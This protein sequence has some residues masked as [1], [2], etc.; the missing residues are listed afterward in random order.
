MHCTSTLHALQPLCL[1]LERQPST[2]PLALFLSAP[3][4]AIP[5]MLGYAKSIDIPARVARAMCP[6]FYPHFA[7]SM[8]ASAACVLETPYAAN[9]TVRFSHTIA[10]D[11]PGRSDRP[12][13][14]PGTVSAG[15]CRGGSGPCLRWP[16]QGRDC[17]ASPK[18][19]AASDSCCK[20]PG[21]RHAQTSNS[22]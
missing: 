12:Y 20:A 4:L 19:G 1:S 10:M 21:S 22:S 8:G 2:Y 16:A 14:E 6:P 3:P 13:G 5:D 18:R 11:R 15:V 7:V 17:T 9:P